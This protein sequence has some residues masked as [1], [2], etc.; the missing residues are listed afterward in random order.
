M[1]TKKGGEE[2][3]VWVLLLVELDAGI[4]G[5]VLVWLLLGLVVLASVVLDRMVLISA[6]LSMLSLISV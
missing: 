4:G 3:S 1:I 5:K 6:L 2:Y